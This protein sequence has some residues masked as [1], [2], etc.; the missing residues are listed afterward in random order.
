MNFAQQ[1]IHFAGAVLGRHRHICACFRT[2][3]EE[4][5]VL[6]PFIKEGIVHKQKAF[7]IVD[8]RFR[9]EHLKRLDSIGIDTAS[10]QDR[11]QLEVCSW[12]EVYLRE[13]HFDQNR[14]L[15]LVEDTLRAAPDRGYGITR[16]VANMQWALTDLPGVDD[17]VEDE[18]R[19]NYILPNYQDPVI[20]TYDCSKFSSGDI[21]DL[22]RTHPS[23]IIGGVLQENPFFVPPERFLAELRERTAYQIRQRE[24]ES[25][26]LIQQALMAVKI[27][28]VPFAAVTAKSFPC[29][30]IGGD[31]FT[32]LTVDEALVVAIGDVAG[33]GIS[34]AIMASLFQGMIHEALLSR[35]SLV[36]I[37]RTI[38]QFI[39]RRG[40]DSKYATM[41]IVC[42]Q[43]TGEVEYL[44]CAHVP[45]LIRT[46][47]G[48][49]MRLRE[50][51]L[52]V[53]LMP[54]ASFESARIR[55][56][57]GDRLIVVTDGVTEAEGY[58]GEFFGDQRL[59]QCALD[60]RPLEQIL[61]SVQLFRGQRRPDDDCTVVELAYAG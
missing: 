30:E 18:T 16:L 3:E 25:A 5:R 44:S 19:L 6:L 26:A 10:A 56:R 40:L 24:M 8:P 51:N 53:G 31:F 54:E 1:P 34:A 57:P 52:P 48:G 33:K 27:P 37:A 20:C 11:G 29:Q 45:P 35:V 2:L 60:E 4:Y 50:G 17:L 61:T 39:C 13:G 41:V 15:A 49:I 55:M 28:E 58:G 47:E 32:A 42:V 21:A 22:M 7:H 59:E 12:H 46:D 43:P 14:M 9:D 36:E 38:N 23:V